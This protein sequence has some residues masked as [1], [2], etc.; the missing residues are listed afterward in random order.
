MSGRDHG[1]FE[2]G[3]DL[4]TF[5]TFDPL[6][7]LKELSAFSVGDGVSSSHRWIIVSQFSA[8]ALM[9]TI[10]PKQHQYLSGIVLLIVAAVL[11]AAMLAWFR[12][13]K[14]KIRKLLDESR[15][16]LAHVMSSTPIVHYACRV[17]GNRFIPT[18]ASPNL[19]ELFGWDPDAMTGDAE[20]WGS[21][22]HSEDRERIV[23]GFRLIMLNEGRAKHVC[24]YRFRHANGHYLWVHDELT[25][26]RNA[27]GRAVEIIGSWLNITERKQAEEA[28]RA[29]TRLLENIIQNAPVRVFW[30]DRK[31]RYLGCNALFARDAGCESP[32]ELIGKADFDLVWREQAKLYRADDALVMDSCTA[33]IGYEE[34]QTTPDGKTICLYTSKVPL[35]DGG[36]NVFGVLGIYEDITERKQVEQA[37]EKKTDRLE[38]FQKITVGRELEMVRLKEEINALLERLGEPKK[39]E[40]PDKLEKKDSP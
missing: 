36:G 15:Q 38:R 4:F 25:V 19:K 13:Q 14:A 35:C 6:Q 31:S 7:A 17:E 28:V 26:I 40:A 30:K 24:E 16:M 21:H 12:T 11:F 33:K 1:S 32:D 39:Y 18:F 23:D 9:Q 22:L 5:I 10:A 27:D 29:S 2:A 20:W 37:L 34:P 8:T 3:G